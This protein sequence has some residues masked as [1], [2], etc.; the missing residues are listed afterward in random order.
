MKKLCLLAALLALAMFLYRSP[1]QRTALRETTAATPPPPRPLTPDPVPRERSTP[2][3]E[4]HATPPVFVAESTAIQTVGE[5]APHQLVNLQQQSGVL[6]LGDKAPA[7]VNGFAQQGTLTSAEMPV[8]KSC[9]AIL[10]RYLGSQPFS[11]AIQLE[12]RTHSPERAWSSWQIV[13]PVQYMSDE[14]CPLAQGTTKYQYRFT[15]F[16]PGPDYSPELQ[17]VA[18]TTFSEPG[19]TAAQSAVRAADSTP[20]NNQPAKNQLRKTIP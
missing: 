6:R 13:D 14:P 8:G 11:T 20:E 17:S 15:L 16:G 3:T 12:I 19:A 7:P 9:R 2:P 4:M 10:I 5:L 1:E 18:V